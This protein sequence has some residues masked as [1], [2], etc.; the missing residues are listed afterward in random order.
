MKNFLLRC[1]TYFRRGYS[2][3][4]AFF[5]AFANFIVIQY[6][7]VISYI[8]SLKNEVIFG[9]L[10]MFAILFLVIFIPLTTV[11]GW[12]DY[13]KFAVPVDTALSAK[14]SPWHRDISNAIILL[15]EG[16][17]KEVRK[18]LKRWID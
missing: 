10:M 14:A 1:W 12:L 11:I 5:I 7:L 2:T 15:S 16:K 18:I 8:P 17:N 3:Y 6:R 13:K 9:N 4:L